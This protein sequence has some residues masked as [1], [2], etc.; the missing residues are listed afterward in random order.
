MCWLLQPAASSITA[1]HRGASTLAAFV[2]AAPVET[3]SAG[4][5]PGTLSVSAVCSTPG[6]VLRY[7]VDGSRVTS[8]SAVWPEGGLTLGA[9]AMAVL[10]KAFVEGLI[11]SP[12]AGGVFGYSR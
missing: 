8:A 6:A 1:I 5:A 10:V 3:V 9:R 2:A 11:E 4:S 12:V 7:T